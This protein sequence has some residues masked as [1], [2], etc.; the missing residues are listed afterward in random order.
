[1]YRKVLEQYDQLVPMSPCVLGH[2]LVVMHAVAALPHL[3]RASEAEA[4]IADA[5]RSTATVD[6]GADG[7]GGADAAAAPAREYLQWRLLPAL[8]AAAAGAG[9]PLA[10]AAAAGQPHELARSRRELDCAFR[11]A[12]VGRRRVLNEVIGEVAGQG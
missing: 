4:A 8:R 10:A 1:M 2:A 5:R 6:A 7:R 12:D 9:G 11:E 3:D